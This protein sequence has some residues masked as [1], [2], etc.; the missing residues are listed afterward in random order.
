MRVHDCCQVDNFKNKVT[1]AER[2]IT[3]VIVWRFPAHN[4]IISLE[5]TVTS[6][7]LCLY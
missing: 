5:A 4:V 7:L 1:K 6:R 3:S 2:S